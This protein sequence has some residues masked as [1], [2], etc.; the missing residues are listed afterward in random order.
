VLIESNEQ[1]ARATAGLQKVVEIGLEQLPADRTMVIKSSEQ[2][3]TN[4]SEMLEFPVE[5]VDR[6]RTGIDQVKPLNDECSW[7]EAKDLYGWLISEW[8]THRQKYK[9]R[10][11]TQHLPPVRNATE[12]K[13]IPPNIPNLAFVGVDWGNSPDIAAAWKVNTLPFC[14]GEDPLQLQL[15]SGFDREGIW[16]YVVAGDL[17]LALVTQNEIEAG[18]Y[19]F[20]INVPCV[21]ICSYPR[22]K[23]PVEYR[24]AAMPKDYGK[25]VMYFGD[26]GPEWGRGILRGLRTTGTGREDLMVEIQTEA[27]NGPR[28]ESIDSRRVFII[29]QP[30]EG[31]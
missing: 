10:C 23:W 22:V 8:E 19:S 18:R 29:D 14:F 20:P 15:R 28:T 27:M 30:T 1:I 4:E 26:F 16:L 25:E 9:I 31:F 6:P 7:M 3:A 13:P 12:P 11:L 2:A 24:N 21:H 17:R 5:Q